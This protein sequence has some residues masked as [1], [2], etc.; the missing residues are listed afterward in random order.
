MR[1]SGL[2][3]LI[4]LALSACATRAPQS[5]MTPGDPY[6]GW[7]RSIYAFNDEFDRYAFGPV[8]HAYEV[9]TPRL[10]RTAA[11]NVLANLRSPVILVNDVLQGA[12]DRAATTSSRFVINSTIGV[13]GLWDAA[14]HFGIDGHREDFG[15]TLA[16]WGVGEGPYLVLPFLGPSNPRDAIGRLVD[17]ALDPLNWTEFAGQESLDDQ[18]AIGRVT[19]GTLNARVNLDDQINTLRAQTEPYV[20]LR[21][22]YQSQ[23]A[24]DIRNGALEENPYEELPDFDDFLEADNI[25]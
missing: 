13:L 7:N 24:A 4:L 12:P 19:I 20:A 15:Q 3:L 23:R 1:R 17:I 16:V 25:Q 5:D 6:E 14:Q 10:G 18:I 22:L 8:A 11:S 2:I 21:R 9:L